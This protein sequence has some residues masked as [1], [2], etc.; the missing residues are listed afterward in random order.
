M[1]LTLRDGFE[2]PELSADSAGIALPQCG[3]VPDLTPALAATGC[4]QVGHSPYWTF[5]ALTP[6]TADGLKHMVVSF[7]PIASGTPPS[8]W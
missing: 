7:L 3:Q 5:L 4:P 2:W 8:R 6:S 1:I